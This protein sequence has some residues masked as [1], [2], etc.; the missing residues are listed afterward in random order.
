VDLRGGIA[1]GSGEVHTTK[2]NVVED[3]GE[4]GFGRGRGAEVNRR[5]GEAGRDTDGVVDDDGEDSVG[6]GEA[7][8]GDEA[9][10][11]EGEEA[12]DSI[13]KLKFNFG[14][15]GGRFPFVER[16]A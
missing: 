8:D 15:A 1:G 2:M 3:G 7:S 6:G 10:G 5:D 4:D 16:E 11:R 9:G 12:D 14:C 13:E